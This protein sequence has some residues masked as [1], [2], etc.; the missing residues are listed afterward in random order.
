MRLNNIESF[1]ITK[2]DNRML[3]SDIIDLEL[4]EVVTQY[5]SNK[6]LD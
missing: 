4:K 6:S 3:T 2:G 1:T 5:G